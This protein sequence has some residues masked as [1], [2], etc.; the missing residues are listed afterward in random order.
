MKVVLAALLMLSLVGCATSEPDQSGPSIAPSALPSA[1]PSTPPAASPS[2]A[3]SH[4]PTA[5]P[6]AAIKVDGIAVVVTNDLRVRSK[7]RVADDSALLAPLLS[8]GREVFVVDG[9]VTASGFDWYQVQP[10]RATDEFVDL[11]FGW[12]AA[13]G[14]DGEPWLSGDGVRCPARPAD[15]AAFMAIR[16]LIGLACF[17]DADLSVAARL[18]QPEATCGVDIGWTIEPDWL[19]STCP[20][21]TFYVVGLTATDQSFD[22][23]LD[24]DLDVRGLHP[25]VE[26]PDLL[27]VRVT[28]HFDHRAAKTC[29]GVAYEPGVKVPLSGPEVVLAC[30]AQFVITAIKTTG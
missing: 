30:R 11:P 25:G 15:F 29:R 18:G 9:P 6:A 27:D 1:P 10:L 21:P 8:D 17:G 26:P 4:T 13:A 2:V 28:G 5:R 24:P 14:K 3:P 22:A 23:V 20:H 16:P 19:G 12:V 7:P